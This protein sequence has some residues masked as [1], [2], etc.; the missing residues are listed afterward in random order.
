MSLVLEFARRLMLQP[1]APY[2]EERVAAECRAIS[3]EYGLPL[4]QDKFGNLLLSQKRGKGV[5]C[6]VL[7]AHMDHPGFEVRKMAGPSEVIASFQGGVPSRYLQAG[8]KVRL[9][10]GD[11]Q[12][13]IVEALQGGRFKI[14]SSASLAL[15][16]SFAVWDLNP[17]HFYDGKIYGRACDDLIGCAVVLA[18]LVE[19]K[20][21]KRPFHVLGI[22]SRAEEV[23]FQGA[24]QVCHSKVIPRDAF[25]I[26][27]ETSKEL[28]PVKLGNGVIIR[29]GDKTSIF[30]SDGT[31]YLQ[32]VA[33]KCAKAKK[34]NFQWQRALM[35][36]GTCEATAYQA[37]GYQTSAVCVALGNYHNCGENQK[38][39]E[40]YVSLEDAEG[41]VTLLVAAA[42]ETKNFRKPSLALAKALDRLRLQG[43]TR[44]GTG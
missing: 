36:G 18:A 5:R 39:V 30:D 16:P 37:Y 1:A 43:K 21:R 40:E 7:A 2:Y 20:K 10:P 3:E 8:V 14:Q 35:S 11:I 13:T 44:L 34:G 15:K 19:L 4:R 12:G 26:S 27:L 9:F 17:F 29:T 42:L 23:G 28:P 6:V 32:D 24:L 25:V 31:L 22:L 33:K 41:M 38:L